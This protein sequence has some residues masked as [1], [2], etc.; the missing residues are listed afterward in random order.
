MHHTERGSEGNDNLEI[1]PSQPEALKSDFIEKT[2]IATGQITT[3]E[4]NGVWLVLPLVLE[5]E[6]IGALSLGNPGSGEM[7]QEMEINFTQYLASVVTTAVKIHHLNE[8]NHK[9][10][11]RLEVFNKVSQMLASITAIT[12]DGQR[13]DIIRDGRFVVPGTS[14]LNKP[15]EEIL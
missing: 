11:Q 9:Q 5:D 8:E 1:P 12:R 6:I 2:A 15:L 14:E 13:K 7:V 3:V 4:E 10:K